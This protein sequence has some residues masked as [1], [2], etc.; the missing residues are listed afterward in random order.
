MKIISQKMRKLLLVIALPVLAS[1]C[2]GNIETLN[3]DTEFGPAPQAYQKTIKDYIH[4]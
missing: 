4:I 3:A 2:A 1:G